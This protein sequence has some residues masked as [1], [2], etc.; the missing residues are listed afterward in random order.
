MAILVAGGDV[1]VVTMGS[2]GVVLV[3]TAGNSDVACLIVVCG[4]GISDDEQITINRDDDRVL[5]G[6]Q[7]N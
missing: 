6:R 1:G 4:G 7:Q 5:P 3:A 2:V